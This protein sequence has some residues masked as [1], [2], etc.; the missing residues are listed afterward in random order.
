MTAVSVAFQLGMGALLI[1]L[2][3]WGRSHA[4][5]LSSTMPTEDERERR[6]QVVARGSLA[7]QVTG[8]VFALMA[9]PLF[10]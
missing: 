4:V 6:R 2:G 10:L 5:Q 8:G 1:L 7:C 3:R 9:I